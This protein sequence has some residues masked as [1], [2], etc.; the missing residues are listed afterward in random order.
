MIDEKT[1][2]A[3]KQSGAFSLPDGATI[4]FITK[5]LND[6]IIEHHLDRLERNIYRFSKTPNMNDANFSGNLTGIALKFK[7]R[8]FE[9]KCK[10]SELKFQK[11]LNAQFEL[12]APLWQ[13]RGIDIDPDEI[14][15][16]FKRNYPQ[17]LPEEAQL[18]TTLKGVVSEETAL[19]LVSFVP[20]VQEEI[21]KLKKE[22]QENMDE[23]IKRSNSGNSFIKEPTS[24][25]E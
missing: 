17:N 14:T 15:Y 7:F 19:S 25:A 18:L 24:T 20:D 1:L 21:D 16:Q 13:A 8:S 11:S 23:F 5:N 6:A 22:K 9:D 12:L 3:V 2:E 10:V 4:Q